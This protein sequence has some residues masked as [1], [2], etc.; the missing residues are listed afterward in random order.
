MD[1]DRNR[2]FPKNP[3][4]NNHGII[5][6]QYDFKSNR[7]FKNQYR[8]AIVMTQL[9]FCFG[10]GKHHKLSVCS[11]GTVFFKMICLIFAI[12]T[13]LMLFSCQQSDEPEPTAQELI[14]KARDYVRKDNIWHAIIEYENAIQLDPENETIYFELAENYML[15]NNINKAIK[16]FQ[17]TATINPKNI[18]AKLRLGQ[19]YIKTGK[20]LKARKIISAILATAPQTIVAYHLNLV[21]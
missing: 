9:L 18:E 2:V 20:F 12:L 19:L 14:D 8:R 16:A 10:Q 4:S 3:I 15:F 7:L 1:D 21:L 6:N 13:T 11:S 5:S 17:K